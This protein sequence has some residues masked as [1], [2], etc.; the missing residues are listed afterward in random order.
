MIETAKLEGEIIGEAKGIRKER[1]AANRNF[2][3]NLTT[4]TDFG[5][6]KIA[7]PVGVDAAWVSEIRKELGA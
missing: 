7:M 6:E 5:N 2:T 4:N 1:T 3:I